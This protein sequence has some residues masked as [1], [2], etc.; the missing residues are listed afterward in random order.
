MYDINNSKQYKMVMDKIQ[1][2][3]NDIY[4]YKTRYE[5]SLVEIDNLKKEINKN[6]ILIRSFKRDIKILKNIINEKNIDYKKEYINI[7]D[8]MVNMKLKP[9]HQEDSNN[10]EEKIKDNR[11]NNLEEISRNNEFNIYEHQDYI[12][13][14]NE[15][16]QLKNKEKELNDKEYNNKIEELEESITELKLIN[17]ETVYEFRKEMEDMEIRH[18][19]ILKQ[20]E[21]E[22]KEINK[23]NIKKKKSSPSSYSSNENND[24]RKDSQKSIF[25]ICPVYIYEKPDNEWK[26]HVSKKTITSLKYHKELKDILDNY[27]VNVDE[28]ID[29]IFKIRKIKDT[30][31]NRRDYK[32][33]IER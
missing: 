33:K 12:K 18:N 24:M 21:K 5:E 9:Q 1:D 31:S 14:K 7:S 23:D 10:I 15:L 3:G 22:I 32:Q 20:K 29:Y 30:P 27:N 19:E 4:Y 13:I 8:K 28:V 25:N 2:I 11:I 6:N 26:Q 16:E 17:K